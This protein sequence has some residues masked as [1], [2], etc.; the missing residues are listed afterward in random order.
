MELIQT[1]SMKEVALIDNTEICSK[2]KYSKNKCYLCKPFEDIE[3]FLERC[4]A[5]DRH[6]FIFKNDKFALKKKCKW[7]SEKNNTIEHK[8]EHKNIVDILRRETQELGYKMQ[9][10]FRR[11]GRW[12]SSM[13]LIGQC[14]FCNFDEKG[15][16]DRCNLGDFNKG[17]TRTYNCRCIFSMGIDP[18]QYLEELKLKN[19]EVFFIIS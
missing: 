15:N 3:I 14:G 6:L 17:L 7:C 18:R 10:P 12:W 8:L 9:I 5:D 19:Y 2:C 1:I 13:F 16:S 4:I 11:L